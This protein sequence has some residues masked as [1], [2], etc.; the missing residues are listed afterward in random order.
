MR[1]AWS[2]TRQIEQRRSIQVGRKGHSPYM[3]RSSYP[4]FLV[5]AS[6]PVYLIQ[7]PP[8]RCVHDCC[9]WLASVSTG[10]EASP[11]ASPNSQI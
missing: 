11:D 6:R 5:D 8:V 9:S 2:V 3:R 10:S 7:H 1:D 4:A